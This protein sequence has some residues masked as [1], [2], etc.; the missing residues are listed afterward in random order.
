MTPEQVALVQQSF[1]KVPAEAAAQLFYDRL[2][3]LD[4]GL[5]GMFS[6]DMLQQRQ[7]LMTTLAVA[8]GGLGDIERILPV[9]EGLGARHAGYGVSAEHYETVGDALLWTLRLGL[10]ASFTSEVEDAWTEAYG[11]LA[12]TMI[13]AAERRAA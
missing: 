5:R 12:T 9:V 6:G 3:E 4:P 13:Q 11:L 1:A 2:F 8:V 10:G 7:K